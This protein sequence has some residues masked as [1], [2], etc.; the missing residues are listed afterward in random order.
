MKTLSRALGVLLAIVGLL[1]VL[2]AGAA[3][4]AVKTKRLPPERLDAALAALK[5]QVPDKND[6]PAEIEPL[7]ASPPLL[8]EARARLAEDREAL[9]QEQA[10]SR[11]QIEAE[12]SELE[13]LR[14]AVEA[15]IQAWEAQAP[16]AGKPTG[17][18]AGSLPGGGTSGGGAALAAHDG[19]GVKAAAEVTARMK[20]KDAA[21]LL[22]GE[23]D[24]GAARILRRMDPKL[25]GKVMTELMLADA[26]RARR[27][28]TLM[29]TEVP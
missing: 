15:R 10:L 29:Q 24:A 23:T 1:A 18:E 26:D 28:F 12:R 14:A 16:G 17:A 3:G 7:P 21:Q 27:M 11:A 25:A 4:I 19:K 2:A 20:P 5:G 22:A 9:R 13:T 8:I 6:K